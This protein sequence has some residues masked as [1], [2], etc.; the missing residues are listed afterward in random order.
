MSGQ[1]VSLGTID[2]KV[3]IITATIATNKT[4]P[5][6]A[7]FAEI[8][9]IGGG[10]G[11]AGHVNLTEYG[12]GGGAGATCIYR[13][14]VSPTTQYTCT[15]G[16]GGP[17]GSASSGVQTAGTAGIT[18][19]I[20]ISDTTFNSVSVAFNCNGGGGGPAGYTSASFGTGG[21]LNPSSTVLGQA[22]TGEDGT[23]AFSGTVTISIG[24]GGGIGGGIGGLGPTTTRIALGGIAYTGGGGGGGSGADTT[25]GGAGGSGY[26]QIIWY[27]STNTKIALSEVKSQS[28]L[29]TNPLKT[30]SFPA[31]LGAQFADLILIG[32]GG[33]GG[34]AGTTTGGAGGSQGIISYSPFTIPQG[35]ANNIY[36]VGTQYKTGT[37]QNTWYNNPATREKNAPSPD[38]TNATYWINSTPK[39]DI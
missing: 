8:Y 25:T 10:G 39:G 37:I 32:G 34:S 22:I 24:N 21:S 29:F 11:G 12:A 20:I 13:F 2:T 30:Y 31:P 33:A 14:P 38:T 36:I 23:R 1:S 6:G 18:T 26:I 16:D 7:V 19:K 9:L 5:T 28:Y 35:A 15:F 3:E 17:A 4:V 27:I